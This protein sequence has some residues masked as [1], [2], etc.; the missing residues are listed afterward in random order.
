MRL[1]QR[2]TPNLSLDGQSQEAAG[3]YACEF[4][5]SRMLS[6]A[7]VPTSP[8]GSDRSPTLHAGWASVMT[9]PRRLSTDRKGES[10]PLG[11]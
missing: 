1:T 8:K 11:N 4:P 10:V 6:A 2:L 5:N 9:P 3:S 7:H